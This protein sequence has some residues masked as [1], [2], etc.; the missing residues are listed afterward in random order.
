VRSSAA[1]L[2][3]DSNGAPGSSAASAASDLAGGTFRLA[4]LLQMSGVG[5]PEFLQSL[6]ESCAPCACPA[7]ARNLRD[8]YSPRFAVRVKISP[9]INERS[10]RLKLAAKSPK[11][12]P[13]V[14][15]ILGLS[16]THVYFL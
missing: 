10:P 11:W 13:A 4:E 2:R 9:P 14:K 12:L 6:G 8:H 5:A 16:P 7:S 15:S 3:A 1:T